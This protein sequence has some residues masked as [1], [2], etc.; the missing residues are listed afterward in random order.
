[1]AL[2]NHKQ[3]EQLHA[4]EKSNVDVDDVES[5]ELDKEM[6]LLVRQSTRKFFTKENRRLKSINAIEALIRYSSHWI[7]DYAV[8]SGKAPCKGD[9]TPSKP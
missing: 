6:E 8:T 1:M 9:S 7:N 5:T 3:Q 2:T 4:N